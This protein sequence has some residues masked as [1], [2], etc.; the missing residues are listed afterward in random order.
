MAHLSKYLFFLLLLGTISAC[1]PDSEKQNDDLTM[2]IPTDFD[3]QGHRGARGL[4]PENTIPAFQKALDLGVQTL[5]LDLVISGDSQVII[6]H[7]PWFSAEF[8]LTPSGEA[9]KDGSEADHNIFKL[10]YT[11]IKAYD[12]GSK[13][14]P[15]FEEQQALKAH[16][17]SLVDMLTAIEAYAAEKNYPAPHYNMEIKSRPKWDN[18]FTPAPDRFVR[19][20]LEVVDSFNVAPRT[21]IQSFDVRTL[22][23]IH[24]Q[25]PDQITAYLVS[26]NKT[27]AENLALLSF[28]PE[29]YSPNHLFLTP[30]DVQD[31]HNKKMKVIP[32]TINSVKDMMTQIKMGVD[33]IITDY[34]DR[35]MQLITNVE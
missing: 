19:L 8:C 21:V 33:G 22:E 18:T 20:V 6:S 7:E 30:K 27:V 12:C 24:Q 16:K 15:K 17:P 13:G 4:L 35:L 9:V 26:N 25:S 23:A 31:A 28:L 32:W 2:E 3:T 14:H 29:I 11:E 1:K 10:T 5:E 34:P